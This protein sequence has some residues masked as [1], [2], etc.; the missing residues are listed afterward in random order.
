MKTPEFWYNKN[1]SLKSVFLA[2]LGTVYDLG[3]RAS[4]LFKG[5]PYRAPVPV[6]CVGNIVAG[7]AGKTPTTAAIV[8]FLKMRRYRPFIVMR[9]Y[10]GSEKGPLRVDP[11]LHTA[12]QVG[13]EALILSQIA[14]CWIGHNRA[15]AI[16]AAVQNGATHIVMDDGF[17][18]LS[19][20]KDIS[21]LVIDGPSG[22][23]NEQLIPA[24]PLRENLESALP[25]AT[26]VVLIGKDKHGIASKIGKKPLVRA[27]IEPEVPADFPSDKKIF[28]FSGIARP[29]KFY[30]TCKMLKLNLVGTRDFPDH[31]CFTAND[32]RELTELASK[33]EAELLTTQ[34]D[35]VRL[36]KDFRKRV[37]VLPIRLV[38]MDV[39][40]LL[41]LT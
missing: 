23:G 22:L 5:K 38:F 36:P 26:A 12:E 18:N 20:A 6:I 11:A 1:N 24:G 4:R 33:N 13:D 27:F 28:A 40:W 15:K 29:E 8:S 21:L 19:V 14:P 32:V 7:G 3:S 25:R 17:Q 9:G 35:W 37:A 39:E 34:K 2:P 16:Q 30:D 31:Y 10:G 41:R